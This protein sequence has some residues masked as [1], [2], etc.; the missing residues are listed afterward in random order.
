MRVITYHRSPRYSGADE[1]VRE[2]QISYFRE[3]AGMIRRCGIVPGEECIEGRVQ[4]LLVAKRPAGLVPQQRQ[5]SGQEV[6]GKC[7][8]RGRFDSSRLRRVGL[9]R[10][11]V[12]MT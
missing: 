10:P 3:G 6:E 2:F 11:K 4:V 1:N 12:F 7:R 8:G 5:V 9:W